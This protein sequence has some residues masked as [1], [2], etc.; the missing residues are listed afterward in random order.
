MSW[1]GIKIEGEK[2]L[3][4]ND[5]VNKS[6]SSNDTFPTGMHIAG[7]KMVV[8]K[9]IPGVEQ[10]L[11]TFKKKSAAFKG[12]ANWTNTFNGCNTFNI[13]SRVFWIRFSIRSWP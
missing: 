10:L 9:T 6:Q 8:E 11:E 5:D 4:P 12:V 2:T 13:G 3:L 7:Y 1:Q